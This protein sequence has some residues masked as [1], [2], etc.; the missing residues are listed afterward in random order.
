MSSEIHFVGYVF[1]FLA[2]IVFTIVL[3]DLLLMRAEFVEREK[4]RV[5]IERMRVDAF[6][7]EHE[8]PTISSMLD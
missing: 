3:R 8:T 2:I 7:A 6:E 4:K 1:L 5:E